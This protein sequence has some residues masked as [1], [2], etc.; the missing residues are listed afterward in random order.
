[1]PL[2]VT[3]NKVGTP[4][5]VLRVLPSEDEAPYIAAGRTD[6]LVDPDLSALE[7]LVARRYWKHEAGSI[8]EYN[9]AEKATQDA[10]EE[11]LRDDR[12]RSGARGE[13]V[14]FGDRALLLRALADVIKDEIN[15]LRDQHGLPPRTLALLRTAI[16]ARIE[17][18]SVDS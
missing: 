17:D 9:A 3:F 6:Y 8:V 15:I 10:A 2:I 1:M 11:A 13:L 18:G 14:G 5:R 16:N 7:G 12:V 4:Q